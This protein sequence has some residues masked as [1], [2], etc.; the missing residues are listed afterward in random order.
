MAFPDIPL[1]LGVEEEYQI[2][3]PETRDLHSYVQ[4]FLEQGKQIF[5]NEEFKPEL[6]QSQIEVGSQVCRNIQEV[7]QE[8]CRL[9]RSV[10][11]IAHNNDLRIAAASTHPFANWSDQQITEA[12]RYRKLLDHMQG[13]ASQLLIFGCHI[14]I[15]FGV[16]NDLMIQIMNQMRYFLPHIL[17]LTTSSPFWQGR[18]TGLKSYRSVVFEMLPRTG[19]PQSFRSYT[20]F[21]RFVD[22]LG[23]VG[24]I[25]NEQTQQPD[26]T[27]I[28]W[29]IRPHMKFGTLEVRISDICTRVDDIVCVTALVQAVA[30]K[31]IKM[32]RNNQ[33][34][35]HYRRAHIVENKW[36]A[37]R[38]GIEG[39]LIDFGKREE[40]PMNF[41]ALEMLDWIDDVVDEL[42]SR[43]ET[44][45]LHT[46]LRNGTRAD[47]QLITYREA[48]SQGKS[49]Q[50]ALFAVV[51]QII[52]ETLEG[53]E[54]R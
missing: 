49:E 21:E 18:Y 8:V 16:Q 26:P 30:F 48:V 35:R 47:R 44:N 32:H 52:E 7:R 39:K 31:L 51:D 29:D 22:L 1:T 5:P 15:G 20:E 13:I 37:M 3:H 41:L 38:Y 9:R 46:I 54:V 40:V 12:E 33:S 34:W 53:T 50:E 2:I 23:R 4:E 45:Y 42:G 43:E 14:H 10:S 17:A 25:A 24:S 11:Q 6:M 36:R 19:I 27:K 28:W